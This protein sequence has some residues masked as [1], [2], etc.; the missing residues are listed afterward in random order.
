VTAVA[1]PGLATQPQAALQADLDAVERRLTDTAGLELAPLAGL[2]ELM[3]A[4]GGK[5]IRPSLAIASTRLG[6]C[7][8]DSV[9]D[10]GAAV[11]TLHAATLVHDDLVDGATVRRGMPTVSAHWSSSATVLAGD[12]LFARAARF[13]AATGS[14]R[15]IDIF[16]RTLQTLTDGEL[17]Q[18][19]G[20]SAQP[21]LEEYE[22][23]IYS[24]TAA[25]FEAACEMGGVLSRQPENTITALAG[26]GRGVGMA[27]QIVDDILD[28]TGTPERMGK[29]VGSDLQSGTVTLPAIIHL[30]RA[31]AV[32][33]PGAGR[34]ERAALAARVAG[35]YD[36]LEAA[37]AVAR[38][39]GES[40][41]RHLSA[42]PDGE[43]RHLLEGLARVAVDR[44]S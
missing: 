29:P 12:W 22:S 43:A 11:E 32:W 7:E 9:T 28:F 37:R 10:L 1:P 13:A 25:L 36:A 2:L 19:L 35:D 39:H 21:T 24:K 33:S 34:D 6:E 42:I 23:R 44:D 38:T 18:L 40:A 8:A 3:F 5:R 4:S 41:R 26:F 16:A 31:G 14:V 17:R 15:V 27:F 20:R 30:E